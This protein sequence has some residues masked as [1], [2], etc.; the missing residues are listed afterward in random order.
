MRYLTGPSKPPS[1][2][3]LLLCA[4]GLH[5]WEYRTVPLDRHVGPGDVITQ[6]AGV[7]VRAC[8]RCRTATL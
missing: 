6:H 7:T 2:F 8:R 5:R 4:A 1:A 3:G